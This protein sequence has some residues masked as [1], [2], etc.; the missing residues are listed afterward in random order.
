MVGQLVLTALDHVLAI[1]RD[2]DLLVVA[3]FRDHLLVAN[4][5]L[6]LRQTV[7]AQKR[8]KALATAL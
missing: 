5:C 8:E 2:P 1:H 6:L 3:L 7:S 4:L